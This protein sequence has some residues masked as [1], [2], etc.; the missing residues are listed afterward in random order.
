MR[1]ACS[2]FS[3]E[4]Y[5][6]LAQ[7]LQLSDATDARLETCQVGLGSEELFGRFERAIWMMWVWDE[8]SLTRSSNTNVSLLP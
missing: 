7:T 2:H 5:H 4:H 1:S 3:T 6:R 8:R